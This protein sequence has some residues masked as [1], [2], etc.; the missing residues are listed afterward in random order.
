VGVG[1]RFMESKQFH[2]F[3]KPRCNHWQY[4]DWE[5]NVDRSSKEY[6]CEKCHIAILADERK[7]GQWVAKYPSREINGY[8][9]NQM[10]A[11]WLKCRDLLKEEEEKD[12]AY[13][14]NFVLGKP[15]IGTDIVIDASLILSNISNRLNDK[16][17]VIMGVDQGLKKHYVVG[18]SQGIFEVGSTKEW[19]DIENIRNKYDAIAV[20][21]ALPDLTSIR[22]I[23]VTT[24]R[25]KTGLLKSNGERT[26]IGGLSG[27]TGTEL[28][29]Q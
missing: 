18:N 24:I 12:K 3:V 15:Y 21:D 7:N 2:W 16:T 20:M 1:K 13:F 9:I 23:F 14:Y 26:R 5:K 8:W 28:S 22:S 29:R 19:R 6:I 25:T 17:Q 11:S 27:R 10:M 4:L